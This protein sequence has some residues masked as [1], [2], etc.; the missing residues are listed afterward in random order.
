MVREVTTV[1]CAAATALL[2]M[3]AALPAQQHNV[4][5]F[6]RDFTAEWVRHDV[7]LATRTRYFSGAEQDRVERQ[8]RPWTL[9]WKKD[10][11]QRANSIAPR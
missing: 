5:E 3:V 7:D 4:D 11:I 10:R 1:I 9:A 6:F 8:L 2:L